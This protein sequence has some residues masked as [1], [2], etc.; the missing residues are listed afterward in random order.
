MPRL[1]LLLLVG[2]AGCQNVVKPYE[3]RRPEF[4]DDPRLTPAEQEKRVRALIAF[5]DDRLGPRSGTAE[6]SLLGPVSH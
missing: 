6:P 2:F 4:A 5:P 3:Y 1:F